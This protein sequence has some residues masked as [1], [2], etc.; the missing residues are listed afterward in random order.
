MKI[1]IDIGH[2]S[3]SADIGAK[4]IKFEDELTKEVGNKLAAILKESGYEI[5]FTCPRGSRT[6]INSLEYRYNFA[7][8]SKAELFIS[9]HFNAFNGK[10]G[11]TEVFVS[12]KN[13]KAYKQASDVVDNIANL[14]FSK[15]GVKSANFAVIQ[16]TRM[17]AMLIEC[18][19]VDSEKDMAIFDADK[20]ASAI[21]SGI[22]GKEVKPKPKN[23]DVSMIAT[24]KVNRQN[25]L[26]PSTEQS[27][28][29]EDKSSMQAIEIGEYPIKLLAD[30]ENHYQ[31]LLDGKEWFIYYGENACELIKN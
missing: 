3:P 27:T 2:N 18:C 19:F 22:L 17:P 28:D 25:L 29:I 26:K 6:V 20:M 12:S 15:R 10:V 30:E 8:K 4:G 21:A 9:I 13:S 31:I 16:N 1:A 11:G 24:L 5:V 14:G 7:N 23:D